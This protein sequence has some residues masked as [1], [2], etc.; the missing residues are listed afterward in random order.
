MGL[1]VAGAAASVDAQQKNV[2]AVNKYN[3]VQADNINTA[4]RANLANLELERTQAAADRSEQQV[5]NNKAGRSAL[6]T[7]ATAAG[8][9]GVAGVSV[10]A[11]L[12]DLAGMNAR[13]N[14][15]AE[16][17]YLRRDAS[18]NAARENTYIDAGSQISS[19]RSAA[20]VDYLGT[21]LKLGSDLTNAY[22]G[23]QQRTS[24][25]ATGKAS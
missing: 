21:G 20:P 4:K 5:L 11:L 14:A 23:Y 15:N 19:L 1:A 17:N 24:T 7:A 13:D 8:E 25:K 22:A 3:Q 10:D 18:I 16:L 12:R 2:K 6:A 9:S